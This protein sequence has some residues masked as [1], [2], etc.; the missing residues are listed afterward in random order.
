MAQMGIG[1]DD[2]WGARV[3]PEY[4]LNAE[5]HMEFK[6]SWTGGTGLQDHFTG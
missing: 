5:G 1:G 2:S 3:L 4:L 6:F